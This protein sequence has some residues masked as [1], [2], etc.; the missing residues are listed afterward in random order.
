[1][2]L[3]KIL[4]ENISYKILAVGLAILL[5]FY[6]LGERNPISERIWTVNLEVRNL[7]KGIYI[8]NTLPKTEIKL[9]GPKQ[10]ILGMTGSH[11]KA[12][13]DLKGK[14]KGTHFLDVHVV[15][16]ED[17]ELVS[18]SPEK[19]KVDL[20]IL[21]RKEFP[22]EVNKIGTIPQDYFL[23]KVEIMPGTC[24]AEGYENIV[25]RIRHIIATVDIS[26]LTYDLKKEVY[27]RAIDQ[28]GIIISEVELKPSTAWVYLKVSAILK[29]EIPVEVYLTG[30][31]LSGY[32][33]EKIEIEPNKVI[34]KGP[35]EKIYSLQVARTVP[36]N[37][38]GLTQNLIISANLLNLDDS[39]IFERKQVN[40][41]IYIAKEE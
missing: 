28:E 20:D 6:I 7:S 14:K 1:M 25:N 2:R 37:V 26:S 4:F 38:D 29:K 32:K 39:I 16:P 5:Y 23:E 9:R 12:Y 15:A 31:P 27:L 24:K 22:I 3:K 17:V 34:A 21:V 11:I 30:K 40:V 19:V 18:I 10:I 33:I 8:T 41:K 13:I 35:R 36:I